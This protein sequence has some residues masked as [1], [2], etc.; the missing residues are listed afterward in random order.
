MFWMSKE[1]SSVA[2]DTSEWLLL[3]FGALLG[4]GIIGEYAQ[5]KWWKDRI[6]YWQICVIVGVLGELLSDGS[7]FL[8]SRRLQRLEGAEL[9]DL[10]NK[11]RNALN[12]AA[13]AKSRSDSAQQDALTVENDI[14]HAKG[15][16]ADERTELNA[17]QSETAALRKG[18]RFVGA[19][20][21]LVIEN[22]S[23]CIDA[24]RPFAGE[25]FE[26]WQER[27]PDWETRNLIETLD[28]TLSFSQ[29]S[30]V[31]RRVFAVPP[32]LIVTIG[33]TASDKTHK[34][35]SVLA[36]V[37]GDIGL[38]DLNRK[39][40]SAGQARPGS[41]AGGTPSDTVVLFVGRHP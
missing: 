10:S 23:R 12:D 28:T 41:L 15:E 33:P 16:I 25:K 24:W 7:I 22:M 29:W 2:L 32:G 20:S 11:A 34:A 17:L 3:I 26:I 6:R 39:K 37:L 8:F 30:A 18:L 4:I 31:R 27:N 9:T 38:T 40:P 5:R 21:D 36:S 14:T 1:S 35:A 19:R 13:T